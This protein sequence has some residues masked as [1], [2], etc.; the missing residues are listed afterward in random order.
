M[1]AKH[2]STAR[3]KPLPAAARKTHVSGRSLQLDL[4]KGLAIWAVLVI[5]VLSSMKGG[6]FTVHPHH[7]WYIALDQAARWC[8]P[9][10]VALSGYG[11]M[12]GYAEKFQLF[13]FL[14]RRLWRLIPLYV[15]WSVVFLAV[16]WFIP[17]WNH[18][19][20]VVPFLEQ[21]LTGRA[22]YQ[23][24]FVPMI[25]QLY[26]LFPVLRWLMLR[27]P[28]LTLLATGAIQLRL[29]W[30]ATMIALST[31]RFEWVGG[32]YLWWD[33]WVGYFGLGMWA[34]VYGSKLVGRWQHLSWLVKAGW[35]G[36]AV[37]LAIYTAAHGIA[38][39]VDPL[40]A[41][42]FTR[43]PVV[44][45]SVAMILLSVTEGKQWSRLKPVAPNLL[46]RLLA[47]SGRYSYH[48][49]LG[50]TLV[51]RLWFNRIDIAAGTLSWQQWWIALGLTAVGIAAPELLARRP[52]WLGGKAKKVA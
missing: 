31:T 22:D 23:L 29:V 35:L 43:V 28:R 26:L 21:L 8:V 36:G 48:I 32:H 46:V 6:I 10:F 9:V 1:S 44:L 18:D 3:T 20:G 4:W 34:A 38:N 5:H 13:S 42:R 11:L 49:F 12:S 30:Q 7:L 41:L 17:D 45:L 24:Y 52:V 19:S 15:W 50:H 27:W 33:A 40:V 37:S 39:G 25:V 14:K 51:F 2:A 16:F 47:W